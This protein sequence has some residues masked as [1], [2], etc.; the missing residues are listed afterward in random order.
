[1]AA[2]RLLI[3][4]SAGKELARVGAKA[5]RS[6]IAVRIQELAHD[7]RPRGCEK[8]AGHPD[9]YRVRQGNFRIVYHIDDARGEVTI[10]KVAD[11]KDVYR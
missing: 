7:P 4:T 2:Y 3:K 9:R 11:R 5:D 10:F 1:V 8:I 6:R